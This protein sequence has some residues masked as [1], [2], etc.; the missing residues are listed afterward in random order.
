[1]AGYTTFIQSP[2]LENMYKLSKRY[3]ARIDIAKT[4]PSQA[5]SLGITRPRVIPT[6]IIAKMSKMASHCGLV[7]NL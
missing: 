3:E 1:M 5:E 2:L 4:K 7:M 6:T